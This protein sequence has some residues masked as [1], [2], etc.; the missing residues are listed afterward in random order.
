[1]INN[2]IKKCKSYVEL[3]RMINVS[4]DR[5][6]K[7]V[8]SNEIDISHFKNCAQRPIPPEDMFV[9]DDGVRNCSVKNR[10]MKQNLI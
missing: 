9:I 8:I 1:M 2:N 3:S 4:R 10:I 7:I 5:I 6:R